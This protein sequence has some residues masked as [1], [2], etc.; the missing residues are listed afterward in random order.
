LEA[1]EDEGLLLKP[2]TLIEDAGL[3]A[4]ELAAV[5]VEGRSIGVSCAL[6]VPGWLP[7]AP[8]WGRLTA[9][10]NGEETAHCF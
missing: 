8:A 4:V 6:A 9:M 7:L 1:G 10:L 5:A 2:A 3:P